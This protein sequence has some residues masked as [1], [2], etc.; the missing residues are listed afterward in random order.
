MSTKYKKPIIIGLRPSSENLI[1][2]RTEN[3][4]IIPFMEGS[5]D[6]II[7]MSIDN[8]NIIPLKSETIIL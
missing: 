4:K 1:P 8:S 2:M 7:P 5:S 6:K 3:S